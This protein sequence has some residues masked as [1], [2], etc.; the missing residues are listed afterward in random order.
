MVDNNIQQDLSKGVIH[1]HNRKYTVEETNCHSILPI[2]PNLKNQVHTKPP[3]L[4]AFKSLRVLLPQQEYLV[5]TAYDDGC[6]IA[7]EPWAH[8]QN[9]NWP[10]HQILPVVNG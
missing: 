3:N 9:P 6:S 8:N 1:L 10:P 5:N 4:I 7:V 2:I